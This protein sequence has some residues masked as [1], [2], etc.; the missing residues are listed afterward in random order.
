MSVL[1]GR[2]TPAS[3]SHSAPRPAT[4]AAA[5]SKRWATAICVWPVVIFR[6]GHDRDL[7]PQQYKLTTLDGIEYI[8]NKD[9][10][11]QQIKDRNGNSLQFTRSGISHSG[12]WALAFTRD[13]RERLARS[14]APAA[15][16]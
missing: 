3:A 7:Q 1:H 5:S 9:F 2:P 16:C 14:A 4:R 15:R 8:L 10:G 6:H 12:G 13:A 11:I